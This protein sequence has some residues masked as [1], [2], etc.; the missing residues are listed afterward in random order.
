MSALT[1]GLT[2]FS[3]ALNG[4]LLR[5]ETRREIAAHDTQF[6]QTP[7]YLFEL[8]LPD[9]LSAIPGTSYLFPLQIPPQ[10]ISMSEPFSV[11]STQTQNGGL[12][13]EEN[14]IVQRRIRIR[15]NTGFWPVSLPINPPVGA[16]PPQGSSFGRVLPPV[17]G[18]DLSGQRH[19][20]W[21]Q[22]S[23]FRTYADLKRDPSTAAQTQLIFHDPQGSEHWLVA[24]MS[25]SCD[26]SSQMP[27]M[28][29]YEI[30]LLVLD[31]AEANPLSAISPDTSL[32]AAIKNA[33]AAT[34]G[35]L[36]RASAAVNDLTAVQSDL[37]RTVHGVGATLGEVST[38]IGA[39][40]DFV[41]GTV[42]FVRSP[43]Q[44]IFSIAQAA[45]NACRIAE[46]ARVLG[47]TLYAWPR[48]IVERF[49]AIETAC[50][51]MG[52]VSS[53]FVR[54]ASSLQRQ[55]NVVAQP[56]S[57]T[58]GPGFG[59]FAALNAMGS[60]AL[61][62]DAALQSAQ[63]QLGSGVPDYPG[64][65]SYQVQQG[66]SLSSLAVK[67]LGSAQRWD[68]IAAANNL[69]P[70]IIPT[71][72]ASSVV[73]S[74]QPYGSVLRVGATINIPTATALSQLTVD[75]PVVGAPPT[76][77]A[78]EQ[79]LG[80]DLQ[81]SL[82][83]SGQYDLTVGAKDGMADLA[84]TSGLSNMAQAANT[85]IT[86]ERGT[87]LLYPNLGLQSIIGTNQASVDLEQTKLRVTQALQ[88]DPRVQSI[89]SLNVTNTLDGLTFVVTLRLKGSGQQTQLTLQ[90]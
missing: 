65:I 30:E 17:N 69:V 13:V 56:L 59:S 62:S 43:Y 11:E 48:P 20:Q 75:V 81:L 27:F 7:T 83:A 36:S 3:D 76:A 77:T 39:V 4:A 35:F 45:E 80:T 29:P 22:D 28:Y 71:Q 89:P 41:A 9:S 19:F 73:L 40:A 2:S 52:L 67:F 37:S 63:T 85:R 38:L 18:N 42:E 87:A 90:A 5:P 34:Q 1:S 70:P 25:F 72:A 16:I 32:L 74:Q 60:A 14:G 31:K 54:P 57:G 44:A 68:V 53:T 51:Q 78:E 66:D 86:V 8:I 12:F 58:S 6:I 47:A 64:T 15:G 46:N 88:D 55:K 84:S 10:G 24:P 49:R 21:L 61:P 82:Q 33:Y 26:R 23:V 50:E 79:L